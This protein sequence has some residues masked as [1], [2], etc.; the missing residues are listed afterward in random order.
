LIGRFVD[1]GINPLGIPLMEDQQKEQGEKGIFQFFA[2]QLQQIYRFKRAKTISLQLN[3]LL[4]WN[5]QTS[6]TG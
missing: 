4:I 5:Q 2:H 1:D 3:H 6:N